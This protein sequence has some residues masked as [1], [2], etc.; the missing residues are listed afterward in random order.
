MIEVV[1]I[2]AQLGD[3]RLGNA[4]SEEGACQP[5]QLL[6]DHVHLARFGLADDAHEGAAVLLDAHETRRLERAQRLAYR[7]ASD[8]EPFGDGDFLDLLARVE[9][10][11]EDHAQH[12]ALDQ[13]RERRAADQGDRGGRVHRAAQVPVNWGLRFSMNALRP[14]R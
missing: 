7:G 1:D 14:S 3:L 13:R 12:L 9:F 11:R 8:A 6:A 2:A 4:R 5:L 10:A